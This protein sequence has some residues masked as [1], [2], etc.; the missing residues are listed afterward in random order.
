MP[1]LLDF[2]EQSRYSSESKK[3][4]TTRLMSRVDCGFDQW[5]VKSFV[6]KETLYVLFMVK[7]CI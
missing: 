5:S 6:I 3:T 4:Y 7:Q 2:L 1:R